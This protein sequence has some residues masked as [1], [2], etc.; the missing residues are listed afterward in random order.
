MKEK[1]INSNNFLHAFDLQSSYFNT[2][3]KGKKPKTPKKTNSIEFT[4]RE[5]IFS[6]NQIK[7]INLENSYVN[8][9]KIY[10]RKL[11]RQKNHRRNILNKKGKKNVR[12]METIADKKGDKK[13]LLLKIK[14][15][16]INY[17]IPVL[18]FKIWIMKRQLFM[19]KDLI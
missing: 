16:S 11:N 17:P 6:T 2:N 4:E 8:N 15:I 7:E 14:A 3:K 13:K 19:I 10:N 12:F 1:N 5:V 18:I 9:D